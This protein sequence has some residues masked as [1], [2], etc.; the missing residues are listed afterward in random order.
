MG[1]DKGMG[2]PVICCSLWRWQLC[3]I[4]RDASDAAVVVVV[5]ALAGCFEG[6]VADHSQGGGC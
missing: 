4:V 5:V 2:R 1:R 6:Y 3:V